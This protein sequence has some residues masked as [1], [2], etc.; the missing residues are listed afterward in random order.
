MRKSLL[1]LFTLLTV[2]FSSVA[3]ATTSSANGFGGNAPANEAAEICRELDAEGELKE[4]GLTRGECVNLFMGPAS[5]NANNFR[6]A[7]CGIEFVQGLTETTS[8]GQC[9]KA[10][11]SFQQQP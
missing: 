1:V 4:F 10:L 5:E 2:L 6:A 7:I 8:K 3:F 9:I 11:R